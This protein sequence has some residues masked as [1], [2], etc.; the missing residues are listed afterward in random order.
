MPSFAFPRGSAVCADGQERAVFDLG[1][2][3]C[4]EL[5]YSRTE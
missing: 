5:N 2:R 4:E 3:K 1:S